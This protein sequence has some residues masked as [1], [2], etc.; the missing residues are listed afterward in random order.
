MLLAFGVGTAS[1]YI[2]GAVSKEMSPQRFTEAQDQDLCVLVRDKPLP[3]GAR[4]TVIAERQK[5]ALRSVMASIGNVC[6]A[7]AGGSQH[8]A[9]Q[10]TAMPTS[11]ARQTAICVPEI[12]KKH[13]C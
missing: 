12:R 1:I 8:D 2:T 10:T 3:G 9:D 4:P 6:I 13:C 11:M 5:N 7:T